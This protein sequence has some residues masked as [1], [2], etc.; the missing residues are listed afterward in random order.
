MISN[1]TTPKLNSILLKLYSILWAHNLLEEH[2]LGAYGAR[3][4]LLYDDNPYIGGDNT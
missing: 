4:I 2:T 1:T 3:L